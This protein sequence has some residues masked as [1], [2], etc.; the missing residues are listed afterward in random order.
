MAKGKAK[1]K[2]QSEGGRTHAWC[3]NAGGYTHCNLMVASCVS[4]ISANAVRLLSTAAFAIKFC[5]LVASASILFS[6]AGSCSA[7][8]RVITTC[9]Q[10]S[11][12]DP[13]LAYTQLHVAYTQC[14]LRI[15]KVTCV[16]TTSQLTCERTTPLVDTQTSSHVHKPLLMCIHKSFVY[17]QPLT[18]VYTNRMHAY[19]CAP[20][21]TAAHR[22]VQRGRVLLRLQQPIRAE[23]NLL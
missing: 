15:H 11:Q 21:C 23:S 8:R 19:T 2:G 20:L 9:G 17:T 3:G 6:H 16:Y 13:L 1:G 14:H 10:H 22:G 12:C 18:C 7:I 4:A 5:P